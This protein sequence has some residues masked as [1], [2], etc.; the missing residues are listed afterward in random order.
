MLCT[1]IGAIIL[2]INIQ[3][4]LNMHHM[5]TSGMPRRPF[6]G[7]HLVYFNKLYFSGGSSF[8][9]AT[10]CGEGRYD[11]SRPRL[12]TFGSSATLRRPSGHKPI[13]V[14]VPSVLP[15]GRL[16]HHTATLPHRGSLGRA[17]KK[18]LSRESFARPQ[19]DGEEASSRSRRESE[20]SSRETSPYSR[21]SHRLLASRQPP[22]SNC[23]LQVSARCLAPDA[24]TDDC[25][26]PSE[27]NA[28][29]SADGKPPAISQA[30]D[31]YKHRSE[32]RGIPS[33]ASE[34]STPSIHYSEAGGVQIPGLHPP[35]PPPPPPTSESSLV[36]PLYGWTNGHSSRQLSSPR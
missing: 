17:A 23:R 12:S 10:D 28:L 19:G 36:E 16:P 35:P 4:G 2:S 21:P 18:K 13:P 33:R 27:S 3:V 9:V 20:G 25:C 26:S 34:Y 1:L 30:S 15:G 11:D 29:L 14:A 31:I 5:T 22:S 32:L 24:P 7:R 6:E 8:S